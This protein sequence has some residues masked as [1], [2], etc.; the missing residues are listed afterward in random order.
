MSRVARKT[1]FPQS[2]PLVKDCHFGV[3]PVNP[4]DSDIRRQSEIGWCLIDSPHL[5]AS[6][7]LLVLYVYT[8][9]SGDPIVWR[10]LLH[11]QLRTHKV[12]TKDEI[13]VVCFFLNYQHFYYKII[14]KC[15]SGADWRSGK[16]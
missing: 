7:V 2:Q 6:I 13:V 3:S 5:C 9:V 1:I 14:W 12:I 15:I 10:K 4:S 11:E 8:P 16:A